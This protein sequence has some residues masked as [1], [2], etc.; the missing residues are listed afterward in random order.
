M[1]IDKEKGSPRIK[2]IVKMTNIDGRL[3]R[4]TFRTEEFL[5]LIQ[6][7]PLFRKSQGPTETPKDGT[8]F[9]GKTSPTP[10]HP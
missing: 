2:I 9:V 5:L 4:S 7:T 8:G 10:L 6:R 1:K 3:F